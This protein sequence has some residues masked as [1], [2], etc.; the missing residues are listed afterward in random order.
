MKRKVQALAP[1]AV[2]S[3]AV[4]PGTGSSLGSARGKKTVP[5]AAGGALTGRGRGGARLRVRAPACVGTPSLRRLAR[6]GGVKRITAPCFDAVRVALSE[7]LRRILGDCAVLVE[8]KRRFTITLPDV[9]LA[10][11][12]Q[13]HTLYGWPGE[14]GVQGRLSRVLLCPAAG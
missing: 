4:T 12:R 11:K 6:R 9:L 8:Y 1:G 2:F 3:P 7:F 5:A 13:G 14:E 10:L